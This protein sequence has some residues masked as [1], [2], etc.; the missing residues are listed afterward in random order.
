MGDQNYTVSES[1]DMKNPEAVK[2]A[3]SQ[4]GLSVG[5]YKACAESAGTYNRLAVEKWINCNYDFQQMRIR[6]F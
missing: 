6:K 5:H 2:Y 1:V 4:I 3:A